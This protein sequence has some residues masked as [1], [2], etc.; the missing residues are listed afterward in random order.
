MR[1]QIIRNTVTELP[2]GPLK[3]SGNGPLFIIG[4]GRCGSTVFHD[5]L[6][7]HPHVV[8]L[9]ALSNRHPDRPEINRRLMTWADF[10]GAGPILRRRWQ[11]VEAY[12]FWDHYYRGFSTPFRDLTADDALPASI[13]RL[14]AAAQASVTSRRPHFLSKITGWPRIGFLNAVYPDARFIHV[15]RDG[16]ATASSLLKV[17]FWWG[18]RGPG[19]WRWGPLTPERAERW[20]AYG[21]SFVALAAL[22]WEI[23][24]EAYEQAREAA[25]AGRILEVRYEDLC[26]DPLRIVRAAAD[27][28][29]L[30]FSERFQ[31]SVRSFRLTDRNDKWKQD[32][33]PAQQAVLTGC[34]RDCLT[35]WGY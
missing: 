14:R 32:L 6:A 7:H 11:P 17:N 29:G 30:E 5:L 1:N 25:P 4:T 28:A 10:P 2:A 23:L 33:S 26:A 22:Q 35:R 12:G 18:W 13:A 15:I 19:N 34:I 27:F 31:R 21:H 8:W 20:K 24:M 9:T 3:A 16:R